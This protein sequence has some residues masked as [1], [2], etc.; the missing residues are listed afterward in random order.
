MAE[1]VI[2]TET[3]FI[4]M[5]P[6]RRKA[7]YTFLL[8]SIEENSGPLTFLPYKPFHHIFKISLQST[9]ME[10]SNLTAYFHQE[11]PPNIF[12]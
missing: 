12:R 10:P 3:H 8:R 4:L 1:Y 6:A 11:S 2:Q 5:P 9:K 7:A